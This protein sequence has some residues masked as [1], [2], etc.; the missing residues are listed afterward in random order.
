MKHKMSIFKNLQMT[1]NFWCITWNYM[2]LWFYETYLDHKIVVLFISGEEFHSEKP[3]GFSYFCGDPN[4]LLIPRSAWSP[5][6]ADQMVFIIN[7]SGLKLVLSETLVTM[8]FMYLC[9]RLISRVINSAVLASL[10]SF[11]S[12]LLQL[13]TL[14]FNS[15]KFC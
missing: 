9:T 14:I 8:V 3:Y 2:F 11:I 4:P 10:V 6:H 12:V 13:T 5:R 1:I 15:F 7:T